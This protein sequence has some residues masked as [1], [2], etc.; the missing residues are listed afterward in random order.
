MTSN[1]K[2]PAHPE[3]RI[4]LKS[5]LAGSAL[6]LLEHT[7]VDRFARAFAA[8]EFTSDFPRYLPQQ[9]PGQG[10]PQSV[11]AGDPTATGAVLWTRVDP[12]ILNGMTAKHVDR[13]L[14]QWLNGSSPPDSI[15]QAILK[16]EF[17][18]LEISLTPDFK[19]PILSGYT[20][21]WKD[22]DNVVK[23]DVDG[24]LAPRTLYYY[25]FIT[26]TGH[27]SPTGRFKTLVA[28]GTELSSARF[29]YIS[30]QDYASGYFPVLSYVAEEELDFIVHLGDYVYESVDESAY[31]NP[32]PGRS[33]KL[34][35]GDSKAFTTEDYRTL[36]RTYRTDPHLQRLHENHAVISIWDDHEYANDTYYPAIAPDDNLTSNPT[37][38]QSA[39]RVWF[40]YTPARVAFDATKDFTD[41]LRIYR[42]VRVGNLCELILTDQR[43]YRSSHPCG[44]G[45]LDRYFTNGCA[46]MNDPNQSMLGTHSGQ[47]EWFLHQ[48]K[49]SNALWKIWGNE[50][51]FTPL[52]VLGRWLNLDAWDGYAGERLEIIR[53]L[54]ENNIQNFI[55]ITGDLHTFEAS[56]IKENFNE[57]SDQN[58]VGVELMGGSVTSANIL[59]MV[60]QLFSKIKNSSNPFPLEALEKIT[61]MDKDI[62]QQVQE[63]KEMRKKGLVTISSSHPLV[64]KLFEQLINLVRLENPWIKLINS[65]THGYCILELSSAKTT[66]TAYS[67]NNIRQSS[68][69]TKSLLFQ[70]EVPRDEAKIDVLH[71]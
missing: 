32:L 65:S 67:V 37:R 49:T 26:Q 25:R 18:L 34:P 35:S 19:K 41:S 56:L 38:R 17:V 23:V 69:S 11:A 27:V 14:V 28:A 52:K 3:R 15:R 30:C 7:G 16:G 62:A 10:F 53:N 51:Q 54:K 1:R 43:L 4:F 71:R 33:I 45:T 40:E 22:F 39:N 60:T 47:K 66:W 29:A 20:P 55:T 48:L 21:I 13:G 12:T 6:L 57:D 63:I 58:A 2:S 9:P 36:Y 24:K 68:T 5:L 50:V 42:T 61:Q 59:D 70:C 8:E 31:Q 44:S 64:E 46:T